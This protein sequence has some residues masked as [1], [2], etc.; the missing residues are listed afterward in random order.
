M[1]EHFGLDVPGVNFAEKKHKTSFMRRFAPEGLGTMIGWSAN[2]R[3]I[4]WLLELRTEEAAEEEMRLVIPM[5]G[6][7]VKERYPNLFQD[8]TVQDVQGAPKYVPKNHK[9]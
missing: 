9:I 3:E 5:L 4:R 6:A 2:V 7:I 1:A 8:F